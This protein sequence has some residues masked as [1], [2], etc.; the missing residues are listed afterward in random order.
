MAITAV[1]LFVYGYYSNY[2][3]MERKEM[4]IM[5]MIM[6]IVKKE[7]YYI[8]LVIV[9]FGGCLMMGGLFIMFDIDGVIGI[10]ISFGM[11]MLYF[12]GFYRILCWNKD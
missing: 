8:Y 1:L 12:Y 6:D 3:E 5:K 11:V 2:N 4:V 9:G 10:V 7:I